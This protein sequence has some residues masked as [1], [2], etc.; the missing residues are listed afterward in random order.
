MSLA[1]YVLDLAMNRSQAENFGSSEA[2]ARQSMVEAQLSPEHQNLLLT[3][4]ADRI[5]KAIQEELGGE[6]GP[7]HTTVRANFIILFPPR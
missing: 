2:A 3:R 5:S 4:D 6:P 7:Q 1:R